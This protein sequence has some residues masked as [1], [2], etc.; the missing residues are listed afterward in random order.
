MAK[1]DALLAWFFTSLGYALV[2]FAILI[3]PADAFAAYNGECVN[4]QNSSTPSQCASDWCSTFKD[5]LAARCQCCN[6][7]CGDDAECL[8]RCAEEACGGDVECA[9][10][11]LQEKGK[12]C[13]TDKKMDLTCNGPDCNTLGVPPMGTVCVSA[14]LDPMKFKCLTTKLCDAC[15]C[16]VRDVMIGEVKAKIC[17]CWK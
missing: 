9:V 13:I 2:G 15:K 10:N 1:L 3:V 7:A 12:Q 17:I 4:C 6:N 5:D 14:D 11:C 16:G 8:K